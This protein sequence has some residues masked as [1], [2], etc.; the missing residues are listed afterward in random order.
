M[1]TTNPL[2]DTP[3]AT[4]QRTGPDLVEVRFKPGKVLSIAGISALLDARQAMPL[5][6]PLRVL[7]VFPEDHVDFEIQ[8]ITTDHYAKRPVDQHSRAV[9]WVTR[10]A[11]NERFTQLYFAYFPSPVPSAIFTE[12][13][14]ARAWLATK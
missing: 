14:E 13:E 5:E 2:I 7:I 3:L 4:I 9:A 1:T 12:E 6:R 8:M 11:H 10:N